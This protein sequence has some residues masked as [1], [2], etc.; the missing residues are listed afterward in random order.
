[1]TNPTPLQTFGVCLAAAL[2][3]YLLD[4]YYEKQKKDKE[5]RDQ[6]N[7]NLLSR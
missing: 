7:D 1:M 5:K 2:V 3:V 6:E 4:W